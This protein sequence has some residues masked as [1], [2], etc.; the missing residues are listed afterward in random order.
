MPNESVAMERV[1]PKC[2]ICQTTP[3]KGIVGGVLVARRFFCDDCLGDMMLIS[4]RNESYDL[5]LRCLD[6]FGSAVLRQV[7]RDCY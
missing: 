1:F 4:P 2:V 3:P 5:V 6:G 7:Y